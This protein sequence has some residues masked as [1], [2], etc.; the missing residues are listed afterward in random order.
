MDHHPTR[1]TRR[2]V[3][4]SG[5]LLPLGTRLQAAT[6]EVDLAGSALRVLM[7][8]HPLQAYNDAI[9]SLANDWGAA[10]GV[11]VRLDVIPPGD[12]SSAI[13]VEL[14][15]GAGHDL[16]ATPMPL[17]HQADAFRDLSSLYQRAE[18]AFGPAASPAAAATTLPDG[19]H[20]AFSIGYAPAPIIYR[21]SI[22]EA[23]G[24]PNGPATWDQLRMTG[25]QIWAEEGLS[26]GFG[27][28]PEPGSE[29]VAAML[30]AAF[31]GA[32]LDD[33]GEVALASGE[34]IAAVTFMAGFA[35]ETMSPESFDWDTARP[36]RLLQD[37]ITALVNDDISALRLA[38]SRD[39]TLAADLLLAPPPAGPSGA[40]PTALPTS[41]RAFHIPVFATSP[42]AA[43]AF[44]L[45]LVESSE[46]LAG[47]GQLVDRPAYGSLVPGLVQAGGWLD[48]DPYGSEPRQKLAMLKGSAAW[49]AAP[50]GPLETRAHDEFLLARMM[51]D[52]ARG[53][54]S[55]EG[56]V[57][58]AAERLDALR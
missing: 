55:P 20:P 29:R 42:D 23:Y 32:M 45:T 41:F 53:D 7:P 13:A 5:L 2:Q 43:E 38:H 28:A 52:A 1:T 15:T 24:L 12:L 40:T 33:A 26:V 11:T 25:A 57:A 39:A 54:L 35:R 14:E 17:L 16:I 22:W 51:A 6:P 10:Q 21:R 34:T 4:R 3:L 46:A 27:L 48:A 18:A 47:S 8:A 58:R 44:L 9:R 31:G 49:T 19:R 56:A 50:A 30:L 36:A 37:G